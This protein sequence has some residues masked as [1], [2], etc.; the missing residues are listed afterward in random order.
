[1]ASS[2]NSKE[3]AHRPSTWEHGCTYISPKQMGAGGGRRQIPVKT[4]ALS[5]MC[6]FCFSL[7]PSAFLADGTCIICPLPNLLIALPL[8]RFPSVATERTNMAASMGEDWAGSC[9]ATF[10][11]LL[12]PETQC[13]RGPSWLVIWARGCGERVRS[14]SALQ[15]LEPDFFTKPQSSFGSSVPVGAT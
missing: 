12:E 11:G 8:I 9:Q 5:K 15:M 7:S 14:G 13:P 6:F 10:W 2:Q 4:L 1:M 3:A